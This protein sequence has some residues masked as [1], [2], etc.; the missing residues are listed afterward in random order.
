MSNK[1][2][3]YSYR[4][5]VLLLLHEHG[6]HG[7]HRPRE[8]KGV[9]DE[10]RRVHG[11]IIGVDGVTIA[12]RNQRELA[13]AEAATE[14]EREAE[15]EGNDLFVSIQARRSHPIGSSFATMP[16]TVFLR[17]LAIAAPQGSDG[18]CS[19]DRLLGRKEGRGPGEAV[20]LVRS[21]APGDR[22]AHGSPFGLGV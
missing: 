13:L 9:A 3:A 18:P 15:A 5:E 16:L 2:A 20:P 1:S 22:R 11:D 14:V 12:V 10:E 7:A 19:R 17:L 4:M 6:F 21:A 8:P